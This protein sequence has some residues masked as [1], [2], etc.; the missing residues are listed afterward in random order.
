[1]CRGPPQNP[2]II[3]PPETHPFFVHN[4][5]VTVAWHACHL[6]QAGILERNASKSLTTTGH[7][8]D[9]FT[10]TNIWLWFVFLLVRSIH[11]RTADVVL[12]FW[13]V[14]TAVGAAVSDWC[15]MKFL[16]LLWNIRGGRG[17][18]DIGM[19]C[20]RTANWAAG[21]KL[22]WARDDMRSRVQL[23]ETVWSTAPNSISIPFSTKN[24]IVL[25]HETTCSQ[26]AL[27]TRRPGSQ[28]VG[29]KSATGLRVLPG[30]C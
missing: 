18:G 15:G 8:G 27:N 14:L 2:T 23:E 11:T 30:S 22:R 19:C 13:P 12:Q 29:S 17:P 20:H 4:A 25:C 16:G 7:I 5:P 9:A 1:M 10:L 24:C 6:S 26:V 3:A 21:Q 28:S